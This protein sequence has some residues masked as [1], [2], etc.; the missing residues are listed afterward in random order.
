MRAFLEGERLAEE[1]AAER[2]RKWEVERR[3]HPRK[4][5]DFEILYNELE[6]WRLQETRKIKA[7]QLQGA[8]KK[9]AFEGLLHKVRHG[10]IAKVAGFSRTA[11][12]CIAGAGVCSQLPAHYFFQLVR[13]KTPYFT[14]I[15]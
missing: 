1:R 4:A 9:A 13:E 11:A 3:M 6:A 7:G 8:E 2:W 12:A 15:S 14:I 10:K 5:A